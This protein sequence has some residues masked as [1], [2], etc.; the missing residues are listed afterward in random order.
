MNRRTPKEVI[1]KENVIRIVQKNS[2]IKKIVTSILG[3]SLISF[4]LFNAFTMNGFAI[5]NSSKL[6]QINLTWILTMFLLG[7]AFFMIKSLD[8]I[9]AVIIPTCDDIEN[10]MRAAKA[11]KIIDKYNLPKKCII[12]GAGPDTNIALGYDK[13]VYGK[14]LDFH[15][16]LYDD[17][18]NK[19]DWMIGMDIRSVN[20]IEN[21][22]ETF[23]HGTEGKYAIVSYPLHLMRFKRI[24][25]DAKKA[26][27]ISKNLEFVYIPTKQRLKWIPY[28]IL[29][30]LKYSIKG[31][32]K[33]FG[34]ENSSKT[35]Q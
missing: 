2:G 12:S 35:K 11:K 18:M 4:L 19:T 15:K 17:L 8:N 7:I 13:N 3:I 6:Y 33:Y 23:P 5:N 20:S 16:G 24:I 14:K 22:L 32:K 9:K 29:S 30:N 10:P 1:E 27:K 26:G 28:E 21:I 31:R 25:N 34:N